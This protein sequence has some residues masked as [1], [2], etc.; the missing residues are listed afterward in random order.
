[1]R[2]VFLITTDNKKFDEW[3][4]QMRQ[5]LKKE[6][7]HA[8]DAFN[9]G[10]VDI[11]RGNYLARATFVCYWEMA[12]GGEIGLLGSPIT[13]ATMIHMSHRLLSMGYEEEAGIA[14]MMISNLLRFAALIDGDKSEEE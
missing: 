9:Q 8:F 13:H 3:S 11:Q 2:K 12:T 5:K 4:K 6:S 14:N 10:F 1:M 7:Q